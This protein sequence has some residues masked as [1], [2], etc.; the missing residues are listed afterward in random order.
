MAS[1]ELSDLQ[2]RHIACEFLE[3][4]VLVQNATLLWE[5]HQECGALMPPLNLVNPQHTQ[6]WQFII[7]SKEII[8]KGRDVIVSFSISCLQIRDYG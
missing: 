4:N 6:L 3:A 5:T 7:E 8:K 2:D 1:A